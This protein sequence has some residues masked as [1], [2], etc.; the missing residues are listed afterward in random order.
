MMEAMIDAPTRPV[1]PGSPHAVRVRCR[2][3]YGPARMPSNLAIDHRP[4]LVAEPARAGDVATVV[5]F[6]AEQGLRVAPQ[7][8]GCHGAARVRG[9]AALGGRHRTSV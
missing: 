1:N 8:A 9:L 5:R 6:A 7:G 4:M 2:R 3:G